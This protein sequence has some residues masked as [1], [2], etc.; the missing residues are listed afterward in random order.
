MK[1]KKLIIFLIVISISLI[2][3]G[4]ANSVYTKEPTDKKEEKTPV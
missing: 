2:G 1:V 4:T 3:I